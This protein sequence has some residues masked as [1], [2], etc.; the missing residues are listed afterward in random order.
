MGQY[1]VLVGEPTNRGVDVFDA[2]GEAV[3][4]TVATEIVYA[5][6]H[7]TDLAVL[8]LEA[9][10]RELR[11]DWGITALMLVP[12]PGLVGEAVAIVS[13]Y[14]EYVTTCHLDGFVYSMLESRYT[15][16][17]SLRFTQEC[18]TFG[19]T[20]GSP[21]ISVA[22]GEIIGV[23]NTGYEGGAECSHNNPCEV[24]EAGE[25]TTIEDGSY[26]QQT[27]W[28]YSC[29]DTDFALDLERDGCELPAPSAVLRLPGFE[30]AT[31]TE[32]D[33][34]GNLDA[35]ETA[36]VTVSLEN[37]GTVELDGVA[38]TLSSPSDSLLIVDAMPVVVESIEGFGTALVDIAVA[39]A[40]DVDATELIQ[41]QVTA[42]SDSAINLEVTGSSALRVH[43]DDVPNSSAADDFE[44]NDVPWTQAGSSDSGTAAWTRVTAEGNT[45]WRGAGVGEHSDQRLE[46]PALEVGDGAFV[47]AW[48]HRYRFEMSSDTFWDGGVVELSTDGGL[49]WGDATSFLD[50]VG[51]GGVITNESGNPLADRNAFVDTSPA[52]PE[53]SPVE[54]DFGTQFAGQSVQLRFRVGTDAAAGDFG[55]EIDDL[56]VAGLDNLPF[57]SVQPHDCNRG[58][59]P[60][61]AATPDPIEELSEGCTCSTAS[62]PRGAT[63]RARAQRPDGLPRDP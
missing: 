10:Y 5:T 20:S 8:R 48:S 38:V 41:L 24:D 31:D 26:G 13:G 37:E 35:G 4:S 53:V 52:W 33:A 18:E 40:D 34:D 57:S 59:E 28:L 14:W 21:V 19:G 39:L 3:M 43:F 47:V 58:D 1:E 51:Y 42:S 29:I 30:A 61:P 56:T 12:E 7:K 50:E 62:S 63:L 6:M 55:W 17:N 36:F 23:N 2:S 32:C 44:S 27:W 54:L 45:T 60:P 16:W 11:D 15:W 49:T 46:S 22:T 9:T 25:V